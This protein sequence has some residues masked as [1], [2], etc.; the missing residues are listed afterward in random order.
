MGLVRKHRVSFL[1]A[2]LNSIGSIVCYFI[3]CFICTDSVGTQEITRLIYHAAVK[4]PLQDLNSQVPCAPPLTES[5]SRGLCFSSAPLRL[6]VLRNGQGKEKAKALTV[7]APNLTNILNNTW[8][9]QYPI[10]SSTSLLSDNHINTC[11]FTSTAGN[12][13]LSC[14]L[15]LLY[16]TVVSVKSLKHLPTPESDIWWYRQMH[17]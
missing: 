12:T 8:W 6:W 5:N 9:G 14:R 11:H 16:S 7:A 10:N 4:M 13:I 2:T 3:C 15:P 17:I 1:A